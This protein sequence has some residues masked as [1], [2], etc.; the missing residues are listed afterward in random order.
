MISSED[1]KKKFPNT[2]T[3]LDR[4]NASRSFNQYLSVW[5]WIGWITF[6]IALPLILYVLYKANLF[7]FVAL[8]TLILISAFTTI[9]KRKQPKLAFQ[10]GE[11]LMNNSADF[12][13]MRMILEDK[14]KVEK[15]G[16]AIF[17][18]EPHDV[19][20]ISICAFNTCLKGFGG[21]KCA[22]GLT[23]LCFKVP[24]MKHIYTWVEAMPVD[25]KDIIRAISNKESPVICPGGVQEVAFIDKED[26]CVMFLKARKG[27][28]KLA[29][30]HGSPLVPVITF[31]LRNAFTAYIPKGAFWASVGRKIGALP[32]MF[33]GVWNAPMGPAKP[34]E[35]VNVV[36]PPIVLPPATENPSDED[37]TK[38]HQLYMDETKR[39]FETYKASFGMGNVSLKIV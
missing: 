16:P 39:I 14:E 36:G 27:V 35:L 15:S 3:T 26:E 6:Y 29:L 4:S 13:Q 10:F 24:L 1:F 22:G 21:H 18:L 9:D 7:A 20:P 31:G 8:I 2:T 30:Q 12:Y 34:T 25:K 28:V 33:F 32:I 37:I 17:L 38:Y 11:W 23:S 5:L 19:L